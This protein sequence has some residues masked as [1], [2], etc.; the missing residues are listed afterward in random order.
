MSGN[1]PAS[2]PENLFQEEALR[3]E[4]DHCQGMGG[5]II[6]DTCCSQHGVVKDRSE[7]RTTRSK[8]GPIPAPN[9]DREWES[10]GS[11]MDEMLCC[12]SFIGAAQLARAEA[13]LKTGRGKEPVANHAQRGHHYVG[14][15]KGISTNEV[16]R[17][18]L[19]KRLAVSGRKMSLEAPTEDGRPSTGPVG[20]K[21]GVR[22]E[23][24][25]GVRQRSGRTRQA[26]NRFA[27]I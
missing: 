10:N 5:K 11:A 13:S 15:Q 24:Q 22:P 26:E 25:V 1:S 3:A 20:P 27:C 7:A 17:D 16:G 21:C 9:P 14:F 19:Y 12:V 8:E 18:N 6:D 4:V 23:L 2:G